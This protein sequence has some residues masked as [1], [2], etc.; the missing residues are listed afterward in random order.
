MDTTRTPLPGHQC[1]AFFISWIKTSHGLGS[2]S[3]YVLW[4]YAEAFM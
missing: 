3:G 1:R 4:H 2:D